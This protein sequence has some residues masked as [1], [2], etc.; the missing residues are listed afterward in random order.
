MLRQPPAV[1]VWASSVSVD[2]TVLT[3]VLMPSFSCEIFKIFFRLARSPRRL[4]RA[5]ICESHPTLDIEE[6]GFLPKSVLLAELT[7][8]KQDFLPS[9]GTA[10]QLRHFLLLFQTLGVVGE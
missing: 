7:G 9:F 4:S 6:A 5:R 10:H 8:V 2:Y 3:P 1:R